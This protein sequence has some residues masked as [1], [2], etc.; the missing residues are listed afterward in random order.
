MNCE[1]ELPQKQV[2]ADK[3]GNWKRQYLSQKG[4][5]FVSVHK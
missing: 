5:H 3:G 1:Q 2:S 4:M